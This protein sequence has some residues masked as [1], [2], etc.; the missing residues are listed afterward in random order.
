MAQSYTK[1]KPQAAFVSAQEA[2]VD[3]KLSPGIGWRLGCPATIVQAVLDMVLAGS[4]VVL[5]ADCRRRDLG[6]TSADIVAALKTT[7]QVD[8]AD[9]IRRQPLQV[10]EAMACTAAH[11]REGRK[12]GGF[13]TQG[14][15]YFSL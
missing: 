5:V 9:H 4:L 2:L 3:T 14:Q 6:W 8:V 12:E 11:Q 10:A 7:A 13:R 15:A 1:S